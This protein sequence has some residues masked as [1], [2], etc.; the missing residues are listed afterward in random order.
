MFP[1]CKIL[2]LLIIWPICNEKS[3]SASAH[4]PTGVG[5][6]WEWG[7]HS[8]PWS[9]T[10]WWYDGRGETVGGEVIIHPFIQIWVPTMCLG[11]FQVE[12]TEDVL[13]VSSFNYLHL[14]AILT[15]IIF[16]WLTYRWGNQGS[17]SLFS[18]LKL[19]QL[20]TELC[21]HPNLVSLQSSGAL[22]DY[23]MVIP[24]NIAVKFIHVQ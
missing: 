13:C 17:K 5:T 15:E 14:C 12:F 20:K 19:H 16:L 23:I 3:M 24:W 4:C 21:L 8:R 22:D 6:E 9:D 10:N 1:I 2:Y 7:L 11:R 18:Y